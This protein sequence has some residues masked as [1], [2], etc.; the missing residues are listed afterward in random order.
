[1]LHNECVDPYIFLMGSAIIKRKSRCL[2]LFFY[3]SGL[4]GQ[5]VFWVAVETKHCHVSFK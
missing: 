3:P 4:K 2:G 1:V 5:L